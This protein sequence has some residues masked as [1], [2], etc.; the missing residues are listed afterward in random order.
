MNK[1]TI[2]DAKEDKEYTYVGPSP[3]EALV[4]AYAQVVK[5]DWHT[6]NYSKYKDVTKRDGATLVAGSYKGGPRLY[7]KPS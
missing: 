7:V 6:W 3:E 2:W 4:A 1:V 5:K